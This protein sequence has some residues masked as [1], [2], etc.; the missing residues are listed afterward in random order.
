LIR[1]AKEIGKSKA[2]SLKKQKLDVG[3][4]GQ[5]EEFG[6]ITDPQLDFAIGDVI[7]SVRNG[8]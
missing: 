7:V 4:V 6:L 3:S 5:S 1:D 2:I 8:K